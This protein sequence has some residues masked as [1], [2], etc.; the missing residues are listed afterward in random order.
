MNDTT[1]YGGHEVL[2]KQNINH[3]TQNTT[4]GKHKKQ[5]RK[6]RSIWCLVELRNIRENIIIPIFD[7]GYISSS[8]VVLCF[9][10]FRR[11]E[12]LKQLLM[13]SKFCH[14][15]SHAFPASQLPLIIQTENSGPTDTFD[16]SQV[17]LSCQS[18]RLTRFLEHKTTNWNQT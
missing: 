11:L 14:R 12:W 2:T 6:N 18:W 5:I 15:K 17:G 9:C 10:V 7:L 8:S 3:K 4:I 1:W 13:F 16:Q